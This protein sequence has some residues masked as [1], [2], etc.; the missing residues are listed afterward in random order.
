MIN[1][2]AACGKIEN[3]V[4][5]NDE[6]FPLTN[7]DPE[8]LNVTSDISRI[9]VNEFKSMT[10]YFYISDK[11][12]LKDFVRHVGYCGIFNANANADSMSLSLRLNFD[13]IYYTHRCS[14]WDDMF[15]AK[16]VMVADPD[17]PNHLDEPPYRGLVTL[18]FHNNGQFTTDASGRSKFKDYLFP[19]T[20]EFIKD[21]SD[22]MRFRSNNAHAHVVDLILKRMPRL[23]T[24]DSPWNYSEAYLAY[25]DNEFANTKVRKIYHAADD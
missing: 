3:E 9:P 2:V 5:D 12:V 19:L 17:D 22:T 15:K 16:I 25:N 7:I 1:L 23:N 8:G 11:G 24:Q 14:G 21:D 4:E 18:V 13:I 20:G 6:R 10:P